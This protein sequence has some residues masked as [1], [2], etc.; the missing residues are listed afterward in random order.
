MAR[1]A[2]DLP[3]DPVLVLIEDDEPTMTFDE[4]L[5]L[6]ASDEPTDVDAG[7]AEILREIREH[8]ER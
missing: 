6:L 5:A 8:G 4:W 1:R 2:E 7:A 3:E